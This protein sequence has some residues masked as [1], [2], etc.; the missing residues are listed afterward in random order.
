MTAWDIDPQGVQGVINRTGAAF[1]PFEEHAGTFAMGCR[2]AGTASGSS[3]VAEALKGFVEHHKPTLIGLK[4]RTERT[5]QGAAK[6]TNHYIRGDEE[7]AAQAQAK[8]A[9]TDDR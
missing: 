9:R 1:A 6:A 2:D 3:Q 5:L 4:N 7:M 8:A